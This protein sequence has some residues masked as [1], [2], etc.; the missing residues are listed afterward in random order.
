MDIKGM[1][2]EVEAEI[3]KLQSVANALRGIE[4]S[5]TKSGTTTKRKGHQWTEAERKAMSLK[6]KARWA[7]QK[8]GAQPAKAKRVISAASRRK[9]AIAQRARWAKAKSKA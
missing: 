4:S 8:P 5:Q 1:I 3:A 6:Q 2:G 7:K 9:M